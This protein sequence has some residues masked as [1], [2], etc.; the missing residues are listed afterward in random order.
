MIEWWNSLELIQHF[1]YAI[2][3]IA[4]IVTVF[5]LLLTI[6]GVGLDSVDIDFDPDIGDTDH[7]SGLGL[8]SVQTISAFFM[9]FGW[10]GVLAINFGLSIP[11][12]VIIACVCSAITMF[13]MLAMMRALM[14][15]QA[16]GN[17]NYENAV[18]KVATVYVTL[19]GNNEDGGG[20]IQVNIQGRL[21]VA[22]ARKKTPGEVKP[23]QQ[24]RITE[25]FTETSV[26]VEEI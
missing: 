18:G 26:V 16:K 25:M 15:L 20:Q 2:G 22:A 19:P 6:L 11:V 24:V 4:M 12:A 9:A 8:F 21:R 3:I 17:L 1:F 5:Q 14:T 10:S 23:G 13:A 7:S